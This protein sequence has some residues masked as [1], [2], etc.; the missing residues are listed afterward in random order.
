MQAVIDTHTHTYLS[1]HAYSTIFENVTVAAQRGLKGI[2][3]TDHSPALSDCRWPAAV[4]FLKQVP[5]EYM[6]IH[7]Y[8]GVEAD[9]IDFEGNLSVT[10]DFF[11]K[12]DFMIASLHDIVIRPGTKEQNTQALIGALRNPQVDILGHPGNPNFPVDIEAV[13]KEAAKQHKLIE[14]NSHSFEFRKGCEENCRQFALLCKQYGVRISISSDAHTCFDVGNF[15][16]AFTLLESIDFPQ[17]QVV[18]RS[19]ESFEAYLAERRERI[20]HV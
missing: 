8:R 6:G 2:V 3:N 4:N 13:V 12:V 1:G 5:R 17:E 10:S 18:T 11:P 9:V 16:N 15:K 14:I 20:S 19:L 7:I